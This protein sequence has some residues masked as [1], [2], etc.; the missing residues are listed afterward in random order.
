[1]VSIKGDLPEATENLK[2]LMSAQDKTKLNNIDGNIIKLAEEG[3]TLTDDGIYLIVPSVVKIT[4]TGNSIT[5]GNYPNNYSLDSFYWIKFENNSY[6]GTV[7][8]GDG[9][10][11]QVNG[12]EGRVSHTYE[13][14]LNNHE[15]IIENVIFL[16]EYC[17]ANASNITSVFI[18]KKV[19]EIES[20]CFSNCTGLNNINIPNTITQLDDDTFTG[21]T[22]LTSINIPSSVTKIIGAFKG[23]TGLTSIVIPPSVTELTWSAFENCTSLTS[24]TIPS[25]VIDFYGYVFNSCD[26]LIDYQL[27]W[28]SEIPSYDSDNMPDNENTVFTIPYGKTED[29]VEAG[30]PSEKL[31]ERS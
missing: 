14:G 28:T 1:M 22:G 9:T 2:G 23:C 29:Y 16:G 17:F 20:D 7:N 21:C 4:I 13:D 25:S 15:I 5:L 10:S 27:Y 12:Q 26:S 6:N 18:P 3:E 19:N 24:V 31:V 30:Y 8:W 11:T